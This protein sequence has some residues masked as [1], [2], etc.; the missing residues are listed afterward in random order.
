MFL[1]IIHPLTVLD[2]TW[3]GGHR[4]ST[5]THYAAHLLNRAIHLLVL[6]RQPLAAHFAIGPWQNWNPHFLCE[7]GRMSPFGVV[8]PP[9]LSIK[10]ENFSLENCSAKR[11]RQQP[12]TTAS[13]E[14]I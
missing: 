6:P 7:E 11:F 3:R 4:I 12:E 9:I 2:T 14:S 1:T 10:Q 8:P 5:Y 13:L